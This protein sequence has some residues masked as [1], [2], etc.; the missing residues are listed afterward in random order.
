M[1]ERALGLPRGRFLVMTRE[2]IL[3]LLPPDVDLA[4]CVGRC[5]IETGRN[6]GADYVVSGRIIR[7]GGGLRVAMKL[8]DTQSAGL[9]AS[10]RASADAVIGLEGSVE[11]AAQRLFEP[12][13][14]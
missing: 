4:A 9:V 5:E 8:H 12:L 10:G 1:R 3:A 7:F 13:R 14:L 2:N 11:V 6:I